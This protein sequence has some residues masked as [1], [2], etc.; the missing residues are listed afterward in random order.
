M[1]HRRE[2]YDRRS[3]GIEE[4]GHCFVSTLLYF[5]LALVTFPYFCKSSAQT[6]SCQLTV[7]GARA[8]KFQ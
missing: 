3:G 5:V 4:T 1:P 2:R 7:N 6:S 8:K